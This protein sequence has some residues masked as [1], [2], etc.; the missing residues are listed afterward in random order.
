MTAMS[1]DKVI[2]LHGVLEPGRVEGRRSTAVGRGSER[3]AAG[4]PAFAD[5]TQHTGLSARDLL[6]T[7]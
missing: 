4:P 1:T 2:A 5:E 7:S 6:E 3:S